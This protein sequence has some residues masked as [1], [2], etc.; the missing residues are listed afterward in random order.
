MTGPGQDRNAPSPQGDGNGDLRFQ[1]SRFKE[2]GL[3]SLAV[4]NRIAVLVL[5]VMITVGGL[6]SYLSIPKESSPAIEIPMIAVNTL[7]P[8]VSPSDME[9]LV[10]RPI[11]EELNRIADLKELTSTSVEG[12]SSVV[13]EFETGVVI[14][15]ALARV[16]EKVDLARSKLPSDAEDPS[17]MEF[18]FSEVPIMQVNLSGEYGLVRLK[19]IGEELQDRIEQIP[20]ILRGDLMRR[21]ERELKFYLDLPKLKF[22]GL[23]MSDIV[24]AIRNENVNI[25]GGS[26]EAGTLNYLV[27]VDG[28]FRDPSLLGDIVVTTSG[29][30]PIYIRDVAD[31][32]FAFADRDSYARL[33]EAPVITL[34]VIKRSGDNIIETA[35]AVRSS[36]AGMESLFP[37]TTVV[38]ITSDQSE[39]IYEMVSSLENNI[40]SG[41]ILIV[42]VLLFFLGIRNSLFVAVAIPT[43]M[44]LS[45][46]ALGVLGITMNMVVLFSLILALGM[47][48]DNAIVVVE[49]IYRYMEEGWDRVDA[50]KKAT[51]EVAVPVIAATATTLAAFAPLLFWPGIAGEFMKYLPM[52]LIVTLASSLFVALVIVPTLC[53]MFMRLET[54]PRAPLTRPAKFTLLGLGAAVLLG[55]AAVNWLTMALLLA[56]AAILVLAHRLFLDRAG[57]AFQFRTLPVLVDRY[58]GSLRWALNHRLA[59]ILGS[60]AILVLTVAAFTRFNSGV[61]YFPESIPPAQIWV[62]VEAPTGTRAETTDAVAQRLEQLV[63][64]YEGFADVQSKV[65]TVGGG[66]GSGDALMGA[67]P[68]GPEAGRITLSFVDFN[69]RQFDAFDYLA[70]LQEQLGTQVAG[71]EVTVD[72]PADGPPSG[73]PVNLEIVGED[74][75]TIQRLSN[76]V[77]AILQDAPV[78]SKLVGLESD[79][80]DARPELTV[81]VDREK[82]ALFGLNTTDVGMAIRGAIQ[83]IEAA[84]YRT[85]N[86]EF[87]IIVRLAESYRN[88]LDA[89]ADLT[90]VAEGGAQIPLLSV[91]TWQLQ[92]GAG[93]IRRKDMDRVAT[94]SSDV[95]AGLNSN[96]VLGEVKVVLADFEAA[97][98]PGYELRYT[99]QTEEQ[100]EAVAFLGTAFLVAL[101]LI[102]FILVSQFNSVVKPVIILTSVIMSTAGVLLGLMVFQMPF[103]IIMTGVGVISLAGIVVNNAIVLIDYV[104]ILR[105][106]DGMNRREALVQGG[107]TRFRPVVLTAIT[108]ALG[109]VP[110]AIG[111]NFDFLGLYSSLS[112]DLYWGGEQAAWWG[113]MAIAVIAGIIFA[114]FLT[115]ILVPVM[116]S[117]VDDSTRIFRRYFVQPEK[118]EEVVV[119][120]PAVPSGRRP[121]VPHPAEEREPAGVYRSPLQGPEMSPQGD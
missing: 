120:E 36:V 104:D 113:P 55:L 81:E 109:L 74:P 21:L 94:V 12:Y 58:E 48:V 5:L 44:L 14:E 91:A 18:D 23:A 93:S 2:F 1:G 9:S 101:F 119:A 64:D 107:R 84:K 40:I 22:Y 102:A 46:M 66:G 19:D 47:L 89:L 27:R 61:E 99:G 68:S 106:R 33:D 41:L 56:T 38:K 8:G 13:A 59:T 75:T 105:D 42:M 57:R 116:Y 52:T 49:N 82:A 76:E 30:R 118:E 10:T 111:L 34:D 78:F 29:G 11:E 121:A 15:D 25:P 72:K 96:A 83:G 90:V 17:I 3:T 62:T 71:A 98:P 39:D 97:L 65:A 60:V 7:Y 69:E 67:G 20:S 35:E 117:L 53:A 108:T 80:D 45:F 51:G 79:L 103:G 87:D 63:K 32:E 50:A 110:L 95:R 114:T 112:P 92:Q 16:R 100:D 31:V 37:P 88:D 73:P 85:G 28:E 43:S 115:L 70:M 24:D 26:I 4:G 77:I 86:D 6:A 54:E